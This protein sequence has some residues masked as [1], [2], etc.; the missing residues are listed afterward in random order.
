[1]YRLATPHFRLQPS[2]GG[3]G[4]SGVQSAL[5]GVFRTQEMECRLEINFINFK[6]KTALILKTTMIRQYLGNYI[7]LIKPLSGFPS[8][9]RLSL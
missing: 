5:T 7:N 6:M 9:V 8:L 1:M 2:E 4:M 3:G